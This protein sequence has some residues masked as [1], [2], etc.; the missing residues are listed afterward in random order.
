MPHYDF[1]CKDC[2]QQFSLFFKTLAHYDLATPSCTACGSRELSRIISQV[3]IGKANRD[4]GKMSANEMLSV[5]ESGDKRQ[6]DTLFK[7]VG[8]NP[9]PTAPQDSP[10][11]DATDTK[12]AGS[13]SGRRTQTP[14]KSE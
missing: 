3:A 5:L 4:F 10:D 13:A 6:V 7:Q 2:R 1:R 9:L 11:S 14:D 12:R 8:A